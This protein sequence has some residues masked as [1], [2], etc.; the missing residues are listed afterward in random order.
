[1]A[2]FITGY[3]GLALTLL[4]LPIAIPNFVRAREVAMKT[5]RVNNLRQIDAA[6]Q[7]WALDKHKLRTD[8]PTESDLAPYLK[9]PMPKCPKGGHYEI[10]A[11]GDSPTCSIPEHHID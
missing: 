5:V 9:V 10:N 2:G 6:K 3:V 11:T 8:V 4:L 7:A 1:M